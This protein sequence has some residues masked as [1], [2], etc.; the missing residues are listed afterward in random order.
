MRKVTRAALALAGSAALIGVTAIPS[1]AAT[2]STPVSVA[3]E[4]GVLAI[5]VPVTTALTTAAPGATSTTTLAST[6]VDDTRAGT[7]GWE[8]TVTLPILTGTKPTGAAETITTADATYTA[9]TATPSGEVTVTA[10]TVITDLTTAKPSQ[11]ATAVHGNNT[12]SWAAS[13][14]VPIPDRALADT[15]SGTLTQSVA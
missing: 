9:G 3:V 10:A 11:T 1:F 6:A 8:A 5:S 15:F 4:G 13:L 12:A 2:N 7:V 14:A